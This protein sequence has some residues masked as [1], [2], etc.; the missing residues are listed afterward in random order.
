MNMIKTLAISVALGLIVMFAVSFL[1]GLDDI[2]R[3]GVHADLTLLALAFLFHT[4]AMITIT[5]R[6]ATIVQKAKIKIRF[7]RLFLISLSGMAVSNITPSARMGGEP[8]RAYLLNKETHASTRQSLATIIT[9][10]LFDGVAF[11]VMA[12]FIVLLASTEL[13]L[14]AWITVALIISF[15]ISVALIFGMFFVSFNSKAAVRLA[16]WGSK[17]FGR[18]LKHFRSFKNIDKR[19]EKESRMYSDNAKRLMK[20]QNLWLFGI[21]LTILI[22]AFDTLRTYFIFAAL[23][24]HVPVLV[25]LAVIIIAA[26]MGA[27]PVT[28]GGIGLMESVMIIIYSSSG[29]TLAVAGMSTI[30][31][32]LISFWIFTFIGLGA[33]YYLKVK[34]NGGKK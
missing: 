12:F 9:D 14:P 5:V 26:L 13:T 34:I 24:L 3:V 8:I 29:I 27:I 25:I 7:W 20:D 18:V 15:V 17:K 22:W 33:A 1:V 4:L 21:V 32:R 23:G 6:W 11:T 19:V 28:P 31:D 2:V 16:R 30:L 10:R